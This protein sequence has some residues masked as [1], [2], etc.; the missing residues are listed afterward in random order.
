MSSPAPRTEV[1]GTSQVRKG[2][3]AM[4][5]RVVVVLGRSDVGR[6]ELHPVC[7]ARLAR[8]AEVT[9]ADDVVVLSGWARVPDTHSEAELM[10][11][12]WRGQAREVVVDP[13][14]RTTVDNLANALDDIVRSGAREVLVVT[15]SWHAP[16]AKAALRWLLRSTGVRVRAVTP[17]ERSVRAALRELPLWLLLPF[18]L[19]RARR[20]LLE[21]L[22]SQLDALGRPVERSPEEHGDEAVDDHREEQ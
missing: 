15:S 5:A 13:D 3:E 16:R 6:G 4:T 14:A 8:A 9:T 10:H 1:P 20:E 21:P 22:A 7:A 17:P 19:W 18:E 11:A 2:P 12:A